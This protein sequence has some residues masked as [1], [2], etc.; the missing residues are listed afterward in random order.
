MRQWGEAPGAGRVGVVLRGTHAVVGWR[1]CS[2]PGGASNGLLGCLSP[3]TGT[4]SAQEGRRP[5]RLTWERVEMKLG[6][7]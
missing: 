6:E 3:Q 1:A 5:S 4:G 7:V 2:A